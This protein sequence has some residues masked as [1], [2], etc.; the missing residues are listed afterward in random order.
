MAIEIKEAVTGGHNPREEFQN[1]LQHCANSIANLKARPPG[2]S[3]CVQVLGYHAPGDGGGGLFFWDALSV[4]PDN[5]GTTIIPGS[6]PA[7]GRWIR[8]SDT[9]HSCSVAWFGGASNARH[10]KSSDGRWYQDSAC[11]IEA[12]D[13]SDKFRAAVE[14]I[15]SQEHGGL[16]II[17][18]GVWYFKTPSEEYS[19]EFVRL[20]D[21]TCNLEIAGSGIDTT[22]IAIAPL[23]NTSGTGWSCVFGRGDQHNSAPFPYYFRNIYVHG[24]TVD[25]NGEHNCWSGKNYG[26]VLQPRTFNSAVCICYGEAIRY[27][28]I[29]VKNFNGTYAFLCGYYPSIYQLTNFAIANRRVDEIHDSN[30][31]DASLI[32][33]GATQG[34]IR[35][36]TVNGPAD[37]TGKNAAYEVHAIDCVFESNIASNFNA[38][39][40][41]AGDWLDSVGTKVHNCI[42]T[43]CTVGIVPFSGHG[44]PGAPGSPTTPP[45][46]IYRL[47]VSDCLFECYW[48][49]VS[50][51]TGVF[52]NGTTLGFYD[53]LIS[54]NV[55]VC[56]RGDLAQPNFS[57]IGM[58][59][60]ARGLKISNNRLY[61]WGANVTRGILI[62]AATPN[63]VLDGVT[64]QNNDIENCGVI[65]IHIVGDIL[66]DAK[67]TSPQFKNL[68]ISDNRIGDSG[69]GLQCGIRIDAYTDATCDF[70]NNK[71][72]DYSSSDI[73]FNNSVYPLQKA[74]L[75]TD[76]TAN[77]FQLSSYSTGSKELLFSASPNQ[78]SINALAGTG[79]SYVLAGSA[80]G[81]SAPSLEGN[82]GMRPANPVTGQCYFDSI[83]G[84][85]VWWNGSIGKW[86]NSSGVPS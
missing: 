86:V 84:L 34:F 47:E 78:F 26:G 80:G 39:L 61:G 85:P 63:D 21:H 4:A 82:T 54:D 24:F 27:D 53:I 13:D 69:S 16:V 77:S 58:V 76:T 48:S 64:I 28:S 8:Q 23:L 20:P 56:L 79:A 41:I 11:T 9:A 45:C 67:A 15:V 30:Q 6:N 29:Y 10:Y 72:S 32:A 14:Y 57:G 22:L 44:S 60:P 59:G 81:L 35:G 2:S 3:R 74:G 38:G 40:T 19:S 18:A 73:S 46:G 33:V 49:A 70:L 43:K 75:V 52:G 36:C 5:G 71:I 37:A 1:A 83:L 42:F 62:G 51:I 25:C 50:S 55:M 7:A 17:P 66:G 68:L 31:G 12:S 65:G